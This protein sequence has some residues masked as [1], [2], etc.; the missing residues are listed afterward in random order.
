MNTNEMRRFIKAFYFA[1]CQT[2]TAALLRI[3]AFPLRFIIK[4]NRSL[5][6]IISRPGS[7]FSDNSKYFFVYASSQLNSGKQVVYLTIDRNVHRSILEA[8]GRSVLHP[9]LSSMYLLL[10]CGHAVTDFDWFKFGAYPLIIGS[11]LTQLWHGAPLKHIELD[12][13]RKRLKSTPNWLHP[14]IKLQKKIIGRYPHYDYLVSTSTWFVDNAFRHC[15]KAKRFIA[16]GYP[17]NDILFG[18]PEPDSVEYRLAHLNV[19]MK[20]LERVREAKVE[21]MKICLYVPTFRNDMSDP[22]QTKIELRR[23]SEFAQKNGFIFVLKLHPFMQGKYR[24]DL[25]PHLIEYA[26]VGDIYPLMPHCD[27]LITDYSSIFFDFLLIDRP[28]IFFPY[29]LDHYIS[30]DR[31]MYFDYDVMTPGPKCYAYEE[32]EVEIKMAFAI[33][34]KDGYAN[35]RKDISHLTHDHCDNQSTRRILKILK[36]GDNE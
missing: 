19:D 34:H 22:F 30:Q 35:M 23:L 24:I 33:D 14:A 7:T 31:A 5:M 6:V 27:L 11:R 21:G 20:T 18:W 2:I 15:F 25:F 17:R 36:S 8:G 13:L 1:A 9:S 26:P 10:K 4:R 28:I 16:T 12:L 32:L 3:V 29:D